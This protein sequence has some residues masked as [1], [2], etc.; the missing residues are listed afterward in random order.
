MNPVNLTIIGALIVGV[1]KFRK[2]GSIDG[3]AIIGFAFFSIFIAVMAQ[4]NTALATGFAGLFVI[5]ASLFYGQDM[6]K[7]L[8]A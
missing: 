8:F 3:K 2:N 7:G 5:S 1:G 6:F 4:A